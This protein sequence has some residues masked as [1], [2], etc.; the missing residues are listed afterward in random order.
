MYEFVQKKLA[1]VSKIICVPV[2]S[3]IDGFVLLAVKSAEM[4]IARRTRSISQFDHLLLRNENYAGR[5]RRQKACLN[6]DPSHQ[7]SHYSRY[8]HSSSDLPPSYCQ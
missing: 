7:R 5:T 2:I 3:Q 8:I 4:H 6:N 1:L